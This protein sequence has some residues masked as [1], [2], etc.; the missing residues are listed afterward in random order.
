RRLATEVR[1]FA[2]HSLSMKSRKTNM[3]VVSRVPHA[4]YGGGLAAARTVIR[5]AVDFGARQPTEA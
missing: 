1:L 4:R 3:R 5:I 2:R